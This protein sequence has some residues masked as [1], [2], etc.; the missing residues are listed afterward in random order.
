MTINFLKLNACVVL[1]LATACIT[2]GCSK[3]NGSADSVVSGP[4]ELEKNTQFFK[5][6]D[7]PPGVRNVEYGPN[8]EIVSLIVSASEPIRGKPFRDGLEASQQAAI[9]SACGMF[10]AWLKSSTNSE[11]GF[12]EFNSKLEGVQV[13]YLKT[14][15][16]NGEVTAILTW[17]ARPSKLEIGTLP[18]MAISTTEGMSSQTGPA[19]GDK[20]KSTSNEMTKRIYINGVLVINQVMRTSTDEKGEEESTTQ[21]QQFFENGKPHLE[22]TTAEK[23]GSVKI[24]GII[25]DETGKKTEY[26]G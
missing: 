11:T 9:W 7:G 8:H 26:K 25:W 12:L 18:K 20:S 23:N 2:C 13:L 5:I 10:I 17:K 21:H 19:T 3:K 4:T 16:H 1:V 15:I 24:R 22:E 14:D 6:L